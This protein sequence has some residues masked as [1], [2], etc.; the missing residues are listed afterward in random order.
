V[1]ARPELLLR[2]L[3]APG[4]RRYALRRRLMLA[5]LA[6]M[7][8]PRPAGERLEH[9]GSTY[10]GWTLPVERLR[11]GWRCW[12]AGSGSEITLEREL[13]A[14]F[15]CEVHCVDPTDEAR[16]TVA[17]AGLPFHQYALWSHDGEVDLWA[18]HDPTHQTLSA[19]DL[20]RSGRAVRVASRVLATLTRGRTPDLVKLDIEGGEYEVV[21]TLPGRPEVLLI[22]L[23]PTRGLRA[24]MA[25]VRGLQHDGYRLAARRG[26][27]LTFV[28]GGER[29]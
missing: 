29:P 25:L 12:C 23:H 10:S 17:A 13:A 21:R 22:E 16:A 19:D 6:C 18:A 2:T 4:L 1:A 14:R 15:D 7:A 26:G 28:R 11:P 9:L 24:A 27:D 5:A 8:R 20:Q 3:K